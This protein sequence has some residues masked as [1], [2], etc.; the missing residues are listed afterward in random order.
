MVSGRGNPMGE[1]VNVQRKLVSRRHGDL[2]VRYV[3][4]SGDVSAIVEGYPKFVAMCL[5][6]AGA[7]KERVDSIS[8]GF[9]WTPHGPYA[10]IAWRNEVFVVL[11][12]YGSWAGQKCRYLS[13][14]QQ[15]VYRHHMYTEEQALRELPTLL[16]IHLKAIL[17]K[18]ELRVQSARVVLDLL[19][20]GHPPGL[21][22]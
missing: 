20:P 12:S 10:E 7:T 2:S 14:P 15:Q 16:L 21:V 11:Q 17:Q 8:I 1:I 5:R 4:P 9:T 13:D 3:N 22:H 19:E 6:L 18:H